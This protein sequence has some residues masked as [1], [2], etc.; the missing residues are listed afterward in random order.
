MDFHV[1]F[2]EIEEVPGPSI[3]VISEYQC[4]PGST[5]ILG[6]NHLEIQQSP[7]L[8]VVTSSWDDDDDDFDND[9][10]DDNVF[11][12]FN[13][14]F[15]SIYSMHLCGSQTVPFGGGLSVPWGKARVA[16]AFS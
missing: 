6:T 3:S 15:V 8:F 1:D 16:W 14:G 7:L 9:D 13:D 12:V 2:I 11:V 4:W 10:D 5:V